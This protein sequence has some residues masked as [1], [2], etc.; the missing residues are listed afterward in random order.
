MRLHG[1]TIDENVRRYTGRSRQG[2]KDLRPD[3]LGRPSDILII[4]RLPL[5]IFGGRVDPV[6]VRLQNV[7]DPADHAAVV[8]STL[9]LP[10]V[11]RSRL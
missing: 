8:A 2:V 5:T 10:R 11:F 7:D 9:G 6:A 4:E 1:G 3:A